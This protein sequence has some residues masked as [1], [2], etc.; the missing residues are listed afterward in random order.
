[1]SHP[2]RSEGAILAWGLLAASL[3][4]WLENQIFLA[5]M[6]LFSAYLGRHLYYAWHLLAWL[7]E[8]ST[9]LP[10]GNGLWAEML[11]RL[12]LMQRRHQRRKRRLGKM[13]KRF[14]QATEALPDATVVLNEDFVIDWFNPAAARLLGLRKRDLGLRIDDLLRWP[15]FVDYLQQ[16]RF[17]RPLTLP[18]PEDNHLQLEIRVVPYTKDRYLLIAQDVT[19]IRML[20]RQRRDFVAHASHELRTP[21]TVL[22]G[23]LETLI[24]TEEAVSEP[25][26]PVLQRM[27]QQIR[28][29]Q[30]LI[31]DLLYLGRLETSRNETNRQRPVDVGRL[32]EDI[33]KET[34]QCHAEHA[35]LQ[36]DIAASSRLLGNEEELR[37]AFTNLIVNAVKYTPADG[38][39]VIR[40]YET[41]TG[42]CV[43]VKDTGEGIEAKHI[44]RLTERFYRAPGAEIRNP[45]GT[46]LG[47]AIVKHVLNRHDGW[48]E[49]DSQ[50]GRGS[51]FRCCFP[52]QR[53]C[54]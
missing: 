15:R 42:A 45:T 50:P 38:S 25:F 18:S 8:S 7:Q 33:R 41:D 20:E 23:Y 12:R 14:R 51:S 40:W 2:W 24:D 16:R 21:I 35:P 49:I 29:L 27:D 43:E 32:L 34:E 53:L 48:L 4:G 54:P 52:H 44:P 9:L 17:E 10:D 13:L 3:I 28:R 31:D 47:L 39:I 30:Y 22:K 46:G 36:L 5:L 11:H 19:Q 6:A 26:H 1:M 37:S